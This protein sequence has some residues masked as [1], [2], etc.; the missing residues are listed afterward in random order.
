MGKTIDLHPDN[1]VKIAKACV[2]LHNFVKRQNTNEY[3]STRFIDQVNSSGIVTWE[4]EWRSQTVPL[5]SVN[6]GDVYRGNNS[7][8]DA[9]KLRDTLAD[10]VITRV[11]TDINVY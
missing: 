1:V 5:Y 4:G 3:S 10:Y 6:A 2:I 8:R 11:I 9:Y 7:S